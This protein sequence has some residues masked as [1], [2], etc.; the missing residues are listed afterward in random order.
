MP[1][2][3]L[4][5]LLLLAIL[6]AKNSFAQTYLSDTALSR[7]AQTNLIQ[8]YIDSIKENLRLYNGT[9]FTAAYRSSA[10]HPFFESSEPQ[11]GDIFYN[12]IYYPGVR[13]SYDLTR[14]EII[15]VTPSDNLNIKLITEKVSWFSIQNHLF[16][17]ISGDSNAVNFRR[18]GFYEL[19]YDG[20]YSVLIKR[21]KALEQSSR[22]ENVSKFIERTYYYARKDEVYYAIDS[23]RSL[24]SL[25]KDKKPEVAKYMQREKLDFKK[26]PGNTIIKTINY[27]TQLKN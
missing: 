9:E 25:C 17:Y 20:I 12:E 19:A 7:S 8:L 11:Q 23:R 21:K 18:S 26:D 2:H 5:C 1:K 3:C 22:E 15:F 16:I 24:L 6:T 4:Y 10:G 14:D 13:L 27:Y